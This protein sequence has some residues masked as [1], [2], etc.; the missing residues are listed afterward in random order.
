MASLEPGSPQW[1]LRRLHNR[2]VYRRTDLRTLHDYY[3]GRHRLAFAS[4]KF[5][6]AFG[7]LFLAF[8][9]NWVQVVVDATEDRLNIGGFRVG[10]KL[11]ADKDAWRIW[12]ANELDAQ[13]QLAHCESLICGESYGTVWVG[14]ES[15]T[16][17]ITVESPST[18]IVECHP[19]MRRQ[20]LAGLR[21]WLD[22]WGYEHAELFLPDAVYLYKSKTQRQSDIVDTARVQWVIDETIDTA[23]LDVDGSMDNPFGVVPMVPLVNRPRLAHGTRGPIWAQ[24]E[25]TA[26]LPVQDAVNKLVADMLVAS[27]YT[28]MPQRYMLG[29]DELPRNEAGQEVN[30][31]TP[32]KKVWLGEGD[33]SKM[34]VG[35]FQAGDLGNYVKAIEMLINHIASITRT[36]PHYL[37]PSADRLSG[38]SIKAA[39]TGLVAKVK[40]KQR[41]FG[42]GWE[43]IMRL[44]GQLANIPNLAKAESA[45]TIWEDPESRTEAQHVDAVVKA[46]S[47]GVPWRQAMEDLGY[48][49]QQIDRMYEMKKEEAADGL[50]IAQPTGVRVMER[51]VEPPAGGAGSAPPDALP[52]EKTVIPPAP[53]PKP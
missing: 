43:E 14:D 38:E 24:S 40:R 47:I 1:W 11:E 39:E 21:L 45:E 15:D 26:V 51:L 7:G 12:Q 53:V 18:S 33:A 25:V 2:I 4:E 30:P 36:P 19:K 6:Q 42:E 5:R 46:V 48:S 49:P 20:R 9:D 35:E 16:P 23:T 31:Y 27:E 28:A 22:E 37:S 52:T 3:D 8:A 32:D 29:L 50:L 13:S 41:H 34:K 10:E 44:A 17:E